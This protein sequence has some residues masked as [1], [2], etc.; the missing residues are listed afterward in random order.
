MK[1]SKLKTPIKTLRLLTSKLTQYNNILHCS[2]FKKLG[3]YKKPGKKDTTN[4]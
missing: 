1:I 4:P 3:G 2:Q